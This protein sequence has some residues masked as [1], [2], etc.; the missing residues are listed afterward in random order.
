MEIDT[1]TDS[2]YQISMQRQVDIRN[3]VDGPTTVNAD[4]ALPEDTAEAAGISE[5]WATSIAHSSLDGR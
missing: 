4:D 2:C 5:H 3:F 1:P